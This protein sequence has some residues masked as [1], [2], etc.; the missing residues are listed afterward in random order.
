MTR[1]T[2]ARTRSLRPDDLDHRE[3]EADQDDLQDDDTTGDVAPMIGL[4]SCDT[5]RA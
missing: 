1:T 4:S 2:R 5:T 3:H